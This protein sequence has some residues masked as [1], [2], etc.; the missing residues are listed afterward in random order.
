[1]VFPGDE[2]AIA[3][4][5]VPG[6]GAFEENG[7]VYAARIG[8]VRY[9]PEAFTVTVNASTRVPVELNVD[10]S[11]ICSVR[12][13]KSS[14]AIVDV[15]A[16]VDVPDSAIAGDTDGTI[17][18][19]KVSADYVE[20]INDAF[21]LGDILRAKVVSTQPSLQLTTLGDDLGV[22]KAFCPRCRTAMN[23]VEKAVVCPECDWKD[24]KKLSSLYGT[25]KL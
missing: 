16:R 18:I 24:A 23:A 25:G 2:I 8:I 1:L 19:S 11:V 20:S 13:L 5:F 22:V 12:M 6:P 4:E 9:D 10:D 15:G 3:E 7:K 21:R 14:M 17:H